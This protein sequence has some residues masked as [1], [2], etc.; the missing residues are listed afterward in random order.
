MWEA[1]EG[2]WENAAWGGTNGGIF[3]STDGGTTWTE[4]T[5]GLPA[6]T[7]ADLAVAPTDPNRIYATVA[8]GRPT[9]IYRS[10]DAGEGWRLITEDTRPAARR[11]MTTASAYRQGAP[12]GEGR[13]SLSPV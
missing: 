10:D 1:R 2:P 4:L 5:V 11:A 12:G 13:P 7:Q 9:N 6:V 3:K 8:T